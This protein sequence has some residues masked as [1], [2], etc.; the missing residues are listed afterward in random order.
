MRPRGNWLLLLSALAGAAIA[1]AGIVRAPH[2]VLADDAVAMVNGSPIRRADFETALAAVAADGK[3]KDLDAPTKRRVLE[4]L[5]EEELL[6]QAALELGLAQRDRR[7][8]ADLSSATLAFI[9]EAPAP[10]PTDAE[11]RGLFDESPGFFGG[12][13][14]FEVEDRYFAGT[15]EPTRRRAVAARVAWSNG[16]S[17]VADRPALAVPAGPLPLAKLEQYLG[18]GVARAVVEL[19]VGGITDPRPSGDGLRLVRLT[20][21]RQAAPRFEDVRDLVRAEWRRRRTEGE[22][23][24]FLSDRRAR[25]KVA[26]SSELGS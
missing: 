9:K 20:A 12:D 14:R 11:L 2:P 7:V 16:E 4:R 15:D 24:R 25:A 19:P 22:L 3:R 26:V 6:I 1:T 21:K 10:E 18:P 8:R 17:V 13:A 23:E 5:I